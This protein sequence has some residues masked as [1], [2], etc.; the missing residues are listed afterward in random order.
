MSNF[1]DRVE[2]N[3]P[4]KNGGKESVIHFPIVFPF[5][6][7]RPISTGIHL[8][9]SINYVKHYMVIVTFISQ[10]KMGNYFLLLT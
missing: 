7:H 1:E 5:L 4:I 2:E 6:A 9:S 10:Q 8:P 3:L